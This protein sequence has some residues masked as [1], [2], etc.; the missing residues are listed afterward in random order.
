MF[1]TSDSGIGLAVVIMIGVMIMG[2]AICTGKL[3][4]WLFGTDH[5]E[6]NASD[7]NKQRMKS[8]YHEAA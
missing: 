2:L 4:I 8:A 5:E 6:T 3:I 7:A 1:S